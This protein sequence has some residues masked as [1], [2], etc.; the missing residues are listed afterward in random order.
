MTR[1]ISF[2]VCCKFLA[3]H[4][5]VLY[6][7]AVEIARPVAIVDRLSIVPNS[8]TGML[9]STRM[10]SRVVINALPRQWAGKAITT[11]PSPLNACIARRL[12]VKVRNHRLSR[13]PTHRASQ[14][15][16][17]LA[18]AQPVRTVTVGATAVEAAPQA[19]P[20]SSSG[21]RVR[22]APSPTGNLHV[23]GA[24]TALFNYLY[25][26]QTGGT[27]VLRCVMTPR[28]C[29]RHAPDHTPQQHRRH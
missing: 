20:T 27:M 21:V 6:V 15:Q 18:L 11:A 23:G 8:S 14:V 26:Q 16:H 25:A 22:F 10:Q 1:G 3:T 24:R 9:M 12:P 4:R 2:C 28:W 7:G 17:T 13:T 29:K 19:V 5:S